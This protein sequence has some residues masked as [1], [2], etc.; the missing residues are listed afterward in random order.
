MLKVIERSDFA[1]I[2]QR[3]IDVEALGWNADN[4]VELNLNEVGYIS[5]SIEKYNKDDI[6]N[7]WV[8]CESV[9][10]T[11]LHEVRK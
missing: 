1:D 7:E 5:L 9:F 8:L 11:P 2:W 4:D 10:E 3:E 6:D